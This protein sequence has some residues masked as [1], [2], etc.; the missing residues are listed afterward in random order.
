M[1]ANA[2]MHASARQGACRQEHAG[3]LMLSLLTTQDQPTPEEVRLASQQRTQS[4]PAG[5]AGVNARTTS[6]RPGSSSR[7]QSG[8]PNAHG[9]KSRILFG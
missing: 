4:G 5:P 3:G 8:R 1:H 2:C 9:H 6:G 7:T